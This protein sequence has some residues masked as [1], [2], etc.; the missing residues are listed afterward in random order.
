M[1]LLL[2]GLKEWLLGER[3]KAGVRDGENGYCLSEEGSQRERDKANSKME[4]ATMRAS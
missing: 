1:N 3:E 4:G 2:Q